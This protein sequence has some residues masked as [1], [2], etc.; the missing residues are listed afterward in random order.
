MDAE[1]KIMA[2]L[3]IVVNN[4]AEWA[5]DLLLEYLRMRIYVWGEQQKAE[6]YMA[7][8]QIPLYAYGTGKATGQLYESITKDPLLVGAIN[9]FVGYSIFSDP[10]KMDYY[11]KS[12]VHG[13]EGN[14]YRGVLLERLNN[15]M[16]DSESNA[17]DKWWTSHNPFG[18]YH[19]FDDYLTE[20]QSNIYRQFE[21]EMSAIGWNW[22]KTGTISD[23]VV[24]N[25]I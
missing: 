17:R 9:N 18:H 15:A 13:N 11:P 25:S 7:T 20:L 5:K 10:S 16:D 2:D 6:S 24:F 21:K 3:Q 23:D 12:R 1:I 22:Q 19:F 8:G 14:D 4:V